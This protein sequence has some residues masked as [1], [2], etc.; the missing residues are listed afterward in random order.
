MR[1][2]NKFKE[3]A[4]TK[5]KAI[6]QPVTAASFC[7]AWVLHQGEDFFVIPGTKSL[8]RFKENL[9]AGRVLQ[10]F[11]KEDDEAVRAIVKEL[12]VVGERYA[13]G[14]MSLVGH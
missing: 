11:T 6:G 4:E 10:S 14:G 5:S 2:V 8:D 3:L 13:S 12:D 1:L 7:L 9:S